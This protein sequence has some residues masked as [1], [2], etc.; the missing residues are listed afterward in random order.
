[1]TVSARSLRV[2]AVGDLGATGHRTQLEALWR[3]ALPPEWPSSH[4][5][6]AI[7]S[8]GFVAVRGEDLVGAVSLDPAGSVQFIAVDPAEQRRGTG[9]RLLDAALSTLGSKGVSR[10]TAGNGGGAYIWPGVPNDLTAAVGFFSYHGW[11]WQYNAADLVQDLKSADG[12]KW[13]HEQCAVAIA[14]ATPRDMVDVAEFEGR[15]FA[16]WLRWFV[17]PNK[18]LFARDA[19]G[20]V[21]ATLLLEG[22]GRVS[23]FWPL[24]GDDCGTI[25]CVGVDPATR[26]QG[27]GT[28]IVAAA[29]RQLAARGVRRCHISWTLRPGVYERVGYRPWRS[30]NMGGRSLT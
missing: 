28:A 14:G 5:T 22:P 17:D 29:T 9:S 7:L 3:K 1:M 11:T 25:G 24:L 21:R 30:Y 15:H 20:I 26:G 13:R 19:A 16:Q 8:E 6:L 23:V 18:V 27:I 12:R 2:R 10:V 4:E